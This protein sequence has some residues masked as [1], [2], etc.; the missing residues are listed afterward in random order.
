MSWRYSRTGK[1]KHMATSAHRPADEA[2]PGSATWQPDAIAAR[3]STVSAF[4]DRQF[5]FPVVREAAERT[6][7]LLELKPGAAVL[8]VGCGNGAFLTLLGH[9]VGPEGRAV[10]VDSAPAFVAEARAR[11]A[12]EGLDGC[13]QV[14]EGSAYSLPFNA[15]TFDAAR[16]ERVL[17]HLD[18]PAAALR[19]MVRVV[20]PGGRVV[21][22]EP[23]WAALTMDH[24]DPPAFDLLY[25]RFITRFR[26][27]R[28]GRSLYRHFAE[29]GLVDREVVPIYSVQHDLSLLQQSGMDLQVHADELVAEGA[30]SRERA[31]AA[32][33]WLEAVSSDGTFF[34]GGAYFVVAG[35]VPAA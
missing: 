10:G 26:Q 1:E 3:Q 14:V 11:V 24:P 9:L 32:V 29:A 28:M 6:L 25:A 27:P 16:C 12:T 5:S 21:A 2:D 18:D 22:T 19:E 35:R 7:G 17:M 34:A 33:A 8:D 4:L 13:V 15:D 30:L 23:D 20:R 31:D